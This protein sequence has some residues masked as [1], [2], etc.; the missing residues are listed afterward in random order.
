[1]NLV[2]VVVAVLVLIYLFGGREEYKTNYNVPFRPATAKEEQALGVYAWG[3]RAKWTGTPGF[4]PG[5]KGAIAV[6]KLPSKITNQEMLNYQ[7]AGRVCDIKYMH[8]TLGCKTP[9]IVDNP[10]DFDVSRSYFRLY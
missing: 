7:L 5:P 1:M 4:T 8:D 10:Y 9:G 2:A 3:C 6:C